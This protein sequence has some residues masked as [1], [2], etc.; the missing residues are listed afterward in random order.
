MTFSEIQYYVV[1]I[2]PLCRSAKVMPLHQPMHVTRSTVAEVCTL[3]VLYTQFPDAIRHICW[4]CMITVCYGVAPANVVI[5][6]SV[7]VM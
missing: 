4:D 1:Y 2:A 6:L 5:S 7:S 3:R